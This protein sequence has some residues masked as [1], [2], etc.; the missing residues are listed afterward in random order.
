[1][2]QRPK[3]AGAPH[4]AI[5]ISVT[6]PPEAGWSRAPTVSAKGDRGPRRVSSQHKVKPAACTL[7][8]GLGLSV[9]PL[10]RGRCK[11]SSKH[12][13][14]YTLS[15]RSPQHPWPRLA[16]PLASTAPSTNRLRSLKSGSHLVEL[17]GENMSGSHSNLSLRPKQRPL[18]TCGPM[19]R[20]IWGVVTCWLWGHEYIA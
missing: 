15:S 19:R 4:V 17:P 5:C 11:S 2:E 1:M 18:Y 10:M 9:V 8:S 20:S 16:W 7:D 14:P 3:V 12:Q 13:T 6:F